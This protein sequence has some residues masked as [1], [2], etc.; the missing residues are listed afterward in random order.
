MSPPTCLLLTRCLVLPALLQVYFLW[1]NNVVPS[2]L[3]SDNGTEFCAVIMK[4]LCEM[5]GVQHIR[6]SVGHPQSQ[7]AVERANKIVK[8]KIRGELLKAP[9][10]T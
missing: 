9:T 10:A 2:V 6:G 4:Q 5:F 1:E 8:D 7:G 3:Q